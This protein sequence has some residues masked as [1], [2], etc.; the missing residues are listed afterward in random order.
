MSS[1]PPQGIV[2]VVLVTALA[3][4]ALPT[5]ASDSEVIGVTF[6]GPG[7]V[8]WKVAFSGD[9]VQMRV[10]IE[11][12]GDVSS[13]V[14]GANQME[15]YRLKG[16]LPV[17]ATGA[18]GDRAYAPSAIAFARLP[19]GDVS[20]DSGEG[21]ST[22]NDKFRNRLAQDQEYR[23][24]DDVWT[25]VAVG[26]AKADGPWSF[27]VNV[28]LEPGQTL[29]GVTQGS[30]AAF[31]DAETDSNAKAAAKIVAVAAAERAQVDGRLSWSVENRAPWSLVADRCVCRYAGP[32]PLSSEY[33]VW[34]PVTIWDGPPG[35][36]S[37]EFAANVVT[38]VNQGIG[39]DALTKGQPAFSMTLLTADVVHP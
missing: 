5:V 39:P 2:A 12:A 20:V 15:V 3:M 38:T 36:R 9:G 27:I 37:I 31:F 4:Q 24:F 35:D 21:H 11:L 34:G 22:W 16:N 18:L 29:L 17:G 1:R 19:T 10:H 30:D 7:W 33:R 8:A 28:A 13:T 26:G 32:D 14:I 6:A 23:N 25:F